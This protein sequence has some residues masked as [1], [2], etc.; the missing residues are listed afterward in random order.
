MLSLTTLLTVFGVVPIALT[1]SVCRQIGFPPSECPENSSDL[2]MMDY[3][4]ECWG[5]APN[6]TKWEDLYKKIKEIDSPSAAATITDCSSY[7]NVTVITKRVMKS[8][9][10]DIVPVYHLEY[11]CLRP[12]VPVFGARGT[13]PEHCTRKRLAVQCTPEGGCSCCLND[14][15]EAYCQYDTY[16]LSRFWE[17]CTAVDTTNNGLPP[18]SWIAGATHS[19]GDPYRPF[20]YALECPGLAWPP[21]ALFE[22]FHK[23]SDAQ[24]SRLIFNATSD[25]FS[26]S[27]DPINA[28]FRVHYT[29]RRPWSYCYE[30]PRGP[31]CVPGNGCMCC[32]TLYS[33]VM[34][35][36]DMFSLSRFWKACTHLYAEMTNMELIEI[37]NSPTAE[38]S[39]WKYD[40][41]MEDGYGDSTHVSQHPYLDHGNPNVAIHPCCE[42]PLMLTVKR[43]E[44][45]QRVVCGTRPEVILPFKLMWKDW[46]HVHVE[47]RG[48]TPGWTGPVY[49]VFDR[50]NVFTKYTL[51]RGIT[52]LDKCLNRTD[53]A[54]AVTMDQ[55]DRCKNLEE[56]KNLW[57]SG[58]TVMV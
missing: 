24:C 9:S 10:A 39:R 35:Q 4:F 27:G 44:G 19:D 46:P 53:H 58:Y 36:Y 22:D 11:S 28:R 37:E 26:Q 43:A 52:V 18:P 20:Q 55:C 13:F 5:D 14:Y 48:A 47:Y 38:S 2:P 25:G 32:K 49:G 56:V 15:R 3:V 41:D 8:G 54:A 57:D 45:L 23:I 12:W 31:D 33:E 34:C 1:A 50:L 51:L 40:L 16:R 29:C 30:P 17:S 42:P 6:V 21:H 7:Q